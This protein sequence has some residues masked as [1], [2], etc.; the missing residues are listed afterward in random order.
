MRHL[1]PG[2]VIL[3]MTPP[4]ALDADALL[5]SHLPLL[6][7]FALR[8]SGRPEEA[9]DLVQETLVRAL[10]RARL[11]P[12][13][14]LRPWLLRVLKNLFIDGWRRRG[15]DVTAACDFDAL[16]ANDDG[17]SDGDSPR[18]A[19]VDPAELG[20]AVESLAPAFREVYQLHAEGRDY[21]TIAARLGLRKATV[22]TRLHR[23]RHKLRVLLEA[24]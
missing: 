11:Q 5:L 7:G 21:D 16:P 6:R 15:R 20:R 19:R 24:A 1:A 22:G 13:A 10:R 23:A 14:D 12:S 9:E 4:T 18:W 8:L 2:P 3:A 17:E